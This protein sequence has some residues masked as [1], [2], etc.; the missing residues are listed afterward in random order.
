[1]VY[2]F[3]RVKRGIA[4]AFAIGVDCETHNIKWNHFPGNSSPRDSEGKD[5]SLLVKM[6]LPKVVT[7]DYQSMGPLRRDK[8][9]SSRSFG[10]KMKSLTFSTNSS[11]KTVL[12]TSLAVRVFPK[13]E[14]N[15]GTIN[16]I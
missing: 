6:I 5:V 8:Q 10:W 2:N 4:V 3:R 1:M 14:S 13:N 11:V 15:F 16:N 7:G 9:K 12:R